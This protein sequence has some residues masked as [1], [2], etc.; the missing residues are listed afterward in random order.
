MKVK[1]YIPI[2]I[3]ILILSC[4]SSERVIMDNGNVYEVSGKTI[5]NDGI[6]VTN[7]LSEEQKKEIQDQLEEK[8][9]G[10]RE[11]EKKQKELE[12]K[13]KEAEKEAEKAE[14]KQEELEEKQK[15]LENKLEQRE[16]AR[17]N[18]LRAKKRLEDKRN[19]YEKLK[20]KGKISPNDEKK[21]EERLKDL[22]EDLKEAKNELD[23][24]N[25]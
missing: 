17:D 18:Y 12:E 19:K 25:Q 8:L 4:G 10:Q 1:K 6:D 22:E 11:A 7:T 13:K 14:K 15:K 9:D 23:N 2:L 20:S 21:W 3:S 5:K 24:L 16:K